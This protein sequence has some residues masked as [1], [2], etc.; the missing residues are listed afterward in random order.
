MRERFGFFDASVNGTIVRLPVGPAQSTFSDTCNKIKTGI[1]IE[2]LVS[3]IQTHLSRMWVFKG[4]SHFLGLPTIHYGLLTLHYGLS[5]LHYCLLMLHFGL[6]TLHYGLSMIHCGLPT[7]HYGLSMLHC[8]LPML[9]YGL[10]MLHYIRFIDASLHTVCRG[11]T[12]CWGFTTVCLRFTTVCQ[13]FTTVCRHFTMVCRSDIYVI[14][15][16]FFFC[17]FWENREEA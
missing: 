9:H 16:F 15:S 4:C 2:T 3:V 8:G 6:S 14:S 13:C 5:T 12:V 11:F 1:G 17:C 7:L 10:S